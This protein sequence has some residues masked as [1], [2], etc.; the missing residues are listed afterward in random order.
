[1]T[2]DVEVSVVTLVL[3][4]RLAPR[5]QLVLLVNQVLLVSKVSLDQLDPM[6]KQDQEEI[7][8]EKAQKE[9]QVLVK[10][11]LMAMKAPEVLQVLPELLATQARL[12]PKV[13]LVHRV[14]REILEIEV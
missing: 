6:A 11:V 3:Q 8:E 9:L 12:V 4:V 14:Q 1:M 7:L 13:K 5:D 2:K 10:Q